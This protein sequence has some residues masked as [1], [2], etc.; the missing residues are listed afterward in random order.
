MNEVSTKRSSIL[1]ANKNTS[2]TKYLENI[3]KKHQEDEDFYKWDITV[4]SNITIFKFL[5]N[6]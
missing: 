5:I 2:L 6:N 1:L 3:R 4:I